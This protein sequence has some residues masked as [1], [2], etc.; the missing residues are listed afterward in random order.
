M[1]ALLLGY[2]P[3]KAAVVDDLVRAVDDPHPGVRNN[4]MRALLVFGASKAPP[5]IPFG[6]FVEMLDAPSWTDLNKSSLALLNELGRN[7]ELVAL[8]RRQSVPALV[9]MARWKDRDHS[10]PAYWMLG[11]IGGL[12][13]E[14]IQ[15]AWTKAEP[16]IVIAAAQKHPG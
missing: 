15:D 3:D 13:N 10:Q 12:P 9:A 5:R 16:E 6:P 11:W 4:A 1:A 8:L 14:A 7:P 2:A